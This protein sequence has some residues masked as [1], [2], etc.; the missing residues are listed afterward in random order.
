MSG[1]QSNSYE[2]R[3]SVA[4]NNA[5]IASLAMLIAKDNRDPL[6][7][8]TNSFK[9]KFMQMKAQIIQK[10]IAQAKS[11]YFSSSAPKK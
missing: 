3:S 11:R 6:Y 10:Y 4:K 8:R 7:A 5:A 2:K 9:R 1:V